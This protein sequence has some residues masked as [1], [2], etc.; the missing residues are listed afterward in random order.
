MKVVVSGSSGLIGTGLLAI[1]ILSGSA[2]YALKEFLGLP[3]TLAEKPRHRPT[4]YAILLLAT[5]VGVAINFVH[6][7]PVKALFWSAVINGVVAPPLL[8]LIM[9]LGADRSVMKERTSGWL[10]RTLGWA[11]TILM[12][13]AAVAVIVLQL[14]VPLLHIKM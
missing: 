5:I 1:P 2:A 7:D 8:V 9:V 12:S 4:F 11:A 14:A 13:I 3:G 6:I 10:S